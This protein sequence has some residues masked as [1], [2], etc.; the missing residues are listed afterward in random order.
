MTHP[1]VRAYIGEA[2]RN[3]SATFIMIRLSQ[4]LWVRRI[5]VKRCRGGYRVRCR[6]AWWWW[7]LLGAWHLVVRARVN[8]SLKTVFEKWPDPGVVSVWVL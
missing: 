6:I 8:R 2:R 4:L 3:A 1:R 5:E 7:F